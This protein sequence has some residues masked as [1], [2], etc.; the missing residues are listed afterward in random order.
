MKNKETSHQEMSVSAYGRYLDLSHTAVQKAIA[1][2]KIK[3]G[4]DSQRKKIIVAT[5]DREWGNAARLLKPKSGVS[6]LAIAEKLQRK[7]PK[8]ATNATPEVATATD[9]VTKQELEQM[10]AADGIKPED[11]AIDASMSYE[12]LLRTE[13]LIDTIIKKTKLRQLH[14]E[15]VDKKQNDN[16]LFAFARQ[17]RNNLLAIPD[18]T[19]DSILAAPTKVEAITILKKEITDVLTVLS[20]GE[21]E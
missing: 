12:A 14:G 10:A 7:V 6:K 2:G 13:Q 21:G 5:A 11:I 18:R 15:L 17:I 3:Q 8:P 20:G 19:I 9:D 4:Y 1:T 16:D